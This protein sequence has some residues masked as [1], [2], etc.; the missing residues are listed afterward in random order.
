MA[1][2]IQVPVTVA[3]GDDEQLIPPKARK[4]DELPSHT[5]T[6]TLP[7]CGHIPF[8]DDPEQVARTI[9]ETASGAASHD[10]PLV[11]GTSTPA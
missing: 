3:W 1:P 10:A 4:Q 6:L 8:W 7:G 2:H 11:G 9:L 5:K